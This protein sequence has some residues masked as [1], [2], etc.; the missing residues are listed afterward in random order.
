[1]SL[2]RHRPPPTLV[3]PSL[4]TYIPPFNRFY[5]FLLSP[6]GLSTFL[7]LISLTLISMLLEIL[8]FYDIEPQ[9]MS[10]KNFRLFRLFTPLAWLENSLAMVADLNAMVCFVYFLVLRNKFKFALKPQEVVTRSDGGI[11]IV[12]GCSATL[13]LPKTPETNINWKNSRSLTIFL[14]FLVFLSFALPIWFAVFF[15]FFVRAMVISIGEGLFG[16]SAFDSHENCTASARTTF[17]IGAHKDEAYYF[18]AHLPNISTWNPHIAVIR[19]VVH[20][21]S[22]S[23]IFSYDAVGNKYKAIHRGLLLKGMVGRVDFVTRKIDVAQRIMEWDWEYNMGLLHGRLKIE[24]EDKFYE[25]NENEGDESGRS[26]KASQ[27]VSWGAAI[28]TLELNLTVNGFLVSLLKLFLGKRRVEDHLHH[29]LTRHVKN[30]YFVF[31]RGFDIS[32]RKNENIILIDTEGAVQ[33]FELSLDA[34]KSG[35]DPNNDLKLN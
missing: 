21:N 19:D 1:M 6:F 7:L 22:D 14:F 33:G 26:E 5:N 23:P 32:R 8:F 10:F 28:S 24:V 30:M 15:A 29:V 17:N 2:P 9:Y 31:D 25:P 11:S 27:A 16:T 4:S 18:L 12:D 3:H 20:P 13:S 35:P 34:D